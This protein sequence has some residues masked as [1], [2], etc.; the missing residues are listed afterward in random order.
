MIEALEDV[1]SQQQDALR[2]HM[3]ATPPEDQVT[4]ED[5]MCWEATRRAIWAL[6]GLLRTLKGGAPEPWEEASLELRRQCATC[7]G[8]VTERPW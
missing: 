1:H 5:Q 3:E 7:G 6:E 2:A 8:R 4:V